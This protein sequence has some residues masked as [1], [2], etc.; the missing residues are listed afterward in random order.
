MLKMDDAALLDRLCARCGIDL[1]YWD[2]WGQRYAPSE[3]AKLA[4]LRA[5]GIPIDNAAHAGAALEELERREWALALP[6]ATVR[7]SGS[8]PWIEFRSP[9][10]SGTPHIE[11]RLECESGEHSGGRLDA[12]RLQL[13]ESRTVADRASGR[14]GFELPASPGP[15]YHR[16]VIDDAAGV[17]IGETRLIVCPERCFEP[18]SMAAGARLWGPAVQLY[19]LRSRR[20]WG[21]GDFVDLRRLCETVA[22]MGAGIVGINPLHALFPVRPGDA[23]PY[24]PSNRMAVNVLYLAVE[25]IPDYRETPAALQLV[26]ARE[27]QARLVTL[28]EAELVNYADI[29]ALKF[30]VLELLYRNFRERHLTRD[31]DRGRA[32]REFQAAGGESLRLHALFDTLL[33]HFLKKDAGAWGWPVWPEAYRSPSSP[34]VAAFFKDNAERVEYFEYLQWQADVQLWAASRRAHALGMTVGLYTDLAVGAS[35][36]GAE[37]WMRQDF[38]AA[39]IGIGAP[40]DEFNLKGQNWGLAPFAPTQLAASA[41]E[42]YIAMLRAVMRHAGAIRIDHV[43]ALRRLFWIPA[44][45]EPRDGTY[46]R[47]PIEELFGILAL[48]S[49]RHQCLVIGEDLGTV[50]PEVREAMARYGV[51][52]YRPLFFERTHE[53]DFKP[54]EHYPAQALVAVSTH[55]LPTLHGFWRATDLAAR[56]ALSLFPGEEARTRALLDRAQD[57]VRLLLALERAGLVPPGTSVN[58]PAMAQL[59]D[60]MVLAVHTFIA[61]TPSRILVIQLEDLLGQIEQ[62]NLPATTDD[63]H[64][65]WRRKLSAYLEDWRSDKR[66][67]SVAQLLG[68]ERGSPGAAERPLAQEAPAGARRAVAVPRVTYRLQFHRQ[69]TFEQARQIVPYLA[70]L[71]VSH[72]YA[73]PFLK[74]RPGSTHGYDIVDHNAFNPEIGSEEDFERLIAT[75]RQHGM[76]LMM[77]IVPNHMGV[78]ESDNAWWLDVLENGPASLYA[79]YF[80]IE[81]EPANEVLR[82]KVLL[83]V[84]GLQYGAALEDGELKLRFDAEAGEFSVLYY[85]H[86]FPIDPREYPRILRPGLQRLR[87][88][89]RSGEGL[90]G[91]FES[92]VDSFGHLPS[93][94][95]RTLEKMLERARDRAVRK[96]QLAEIVARSSELRLY[97]EQCL[98]GF[99]G[100]PGHPES[101]DPLHELMEAQAWRLAH[102]RVAGDDINYRRFFDV[103]DLAALRMESE[104]VFEET[105]RLVLRLVHE[106][107]VDALRVDHPDGLYDPGQYFER[108]QERAAP[109]DTI[110][111]REPGEH[112][113]YIAVE[114]ILAQHERLPESW[115]V[116]GTTGYRF[117]NLL[118]GLFVDAASE[119]EMGHTYAAFIGEHIEYEELVHD[120]KVLIMTNA[121]SSEMSVLANMLSRIA[122]ADRRHRDFTLNNLRRALVEIV[123]NFPVYRTYS[124]GTGMGEED[125]RYV[126]WAVGKA[127][128][129]GRAAEVSV[130]DFIRQLLVGT[131]PGERPAYRTL[132]EAFVRRFQQ[133]TSPVTAKAVED[134]SFYVYNRLVSLNEVGG[135]PHTYGISL[136]AFHAASVDRARSWPRT[137]VA[138]STHDNKRSEDVRVRID[139]LSEAAAL[140]RLALRR[141]SR[142]NRRHRTEVAE[143]L[144]PSRNDEYLLYQILLG[145]WPLEPMNEASLEAFRERIQA[146]MIK[147]AREAK[148]KTSWINPNEEY[149]AALSAFVNALLRNLDGNPFLNDFLPA[150]ARVARYGM[151]NSLS[152]TLIKLASPGI[153][154]IYQGNEL[155]DLSLVDPDNRRAVDYAKR[156]ALLD[157]MRNAPLDGSLAADFLGSMHDGRIK[158]Y[159]TWRTLRLRAEL[160]DLFTQ[161]EYVPLLA[162]GAKSEHVCAFARR[163][164]GRTVVAVAPRLVLQLTAAQDALPLGE[165]IWGDTLLPVPAAGAYTDAFTNERHTIAETREPALPMSRA[166]SRFPVALLVSEA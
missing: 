123:A 144:A 139:V 157:E 115:A 25:A 151:L 140:W 52:H 73:S 37:T 33:E 60:S 103:H 7:R 163:H 148:T 138:T 4:L 43:M 88:Q 164:D 75:L 154:D 16:L 118:N 119:S 50:P 77:D 63:Q 67:T 150:Q 108:L 39:H 117:V 135:D 46:V 145:A 155:W 45:G 98:A 68:R 71:G 86:R 78:M 3:S 133:F 122:K 53:G 101:F 128:K 70:A 82:G 15:G 23:S 26:G 124:T 93:R 80:D 81:W 107:K 11:W 153:P 42:P 161:G 64:P 129:R 6:P 143:E 105:H 125:K 84:L 49:Q 131:L 28:R 21:M 113:I 110:G 92:L 19:S 114:K 51:Y 9:S 74:A 12:A 87:A 47:Y 147:A 89:W 158:Q 121:L 10:G 8:R 58:A 97:V 142:I 55:D 111:G 69:F 152:Q 94:D 72:I 59:D 13:L 22:P 166:L 14:Y 136:R 35:P 5:M 99:E 134:T 41:F 79:S 24:N 76:G 137:M 18:E 96:R 48:E 159:V 162:Q 54:P 156:A 126:D 61:R 40:P 36:G 100:R 83:P 2:A 149:E 165:G 102:W 27:F 1:E 112:N 116:D 90:L 146:Y 65:N 44:D 57:R 17:A 141:W 56:E 95:E 29:A 127:K 66:I 120:S 30:Q 109:P 20:N 85:K 62:C 91:E 130:Y 104:A 132:V 31:T 32:F 38:Y 106:G 34:A 160:L